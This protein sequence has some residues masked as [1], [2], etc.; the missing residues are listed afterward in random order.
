MSDQ[1][2]YGDWPP[3]LER[4]RYVG[5]PPTKNEEPDDD[6]EVDDG[7]RVSFEVEDKVIGVA[8]PCAKRLAR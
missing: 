4:A 3:Y 8:Y 5:C 7:V 6:D 1:E 2:E